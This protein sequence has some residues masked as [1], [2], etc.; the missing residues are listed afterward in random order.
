MYLQTTIMKALIKLNHQKS[1]KPMPMNKNLLLRKILHHLSLQKQYPKEEVG[2]QMT[3]HKV[4]RDMLKCYTK[5]EPY[6]PCHCLI[7]NLDQKVDSWD[8]WN[9]DHSMKITWKTISVLMKRQQ[10]ISNF[11]SLV[12]YV[13]LYGSIYGCSLWC[14][15]F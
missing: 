1:L 12:V 11:C 13:C 10:C 14:C 2:L 15:S 6:L 3:Q 7:L 9:I 8:H 5:L 4:P